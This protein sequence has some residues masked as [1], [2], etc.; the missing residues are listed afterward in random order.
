MSNDPKIIFHMKAELKDQLMTMKAGELAETS[1]SGL[2][3]VAIR[4]FITSREA[5]RNPET[6]SAA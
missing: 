1:M 5:K 2:I 3:R 6:P 4:E